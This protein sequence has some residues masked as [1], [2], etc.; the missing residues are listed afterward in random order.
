MKSRNQREGRYALRL[1]R[2]RHLATFGPWRTLTPLEIL[3]D[4]RAMLQMSFNELTGATP[5]A[6]TK[7]P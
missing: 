5:P 7:R 2:K 3:E 6:V 1:S 4:I